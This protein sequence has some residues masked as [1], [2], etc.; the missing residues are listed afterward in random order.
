MC[1]IYLLLLIYSQYLQRY[2]VLQLFLYSG[3]YNIE[4]RLLCFSLFLVPV[5]LFSVCILAVQ[6]KQLFCSY[7]VIIVRTHLKH[8]LFVLS[9]S[10]SLTLY[11]H[12]L[13]FSFLFFCKEWGDRQETWSQGG[14]MCIKAV[15]H[16]GCCSY[17]TLR[18]YAS[19]Y[20]MFLLSLCPRFFSF[21][22]DIM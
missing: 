15:E 3:L 7:S 22:R 5:S 8:L 13:L 21:C 6:N 17:A 2:C 16:L 9:F 14:I 1:S 4:W 10:S 12:M 20:G 11:I 18:Y 19:L